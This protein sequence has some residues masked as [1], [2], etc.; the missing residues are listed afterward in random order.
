VLKGVRI[1]EG[2][3]SMVTLELSID[4][5]TQALILGGVE[6][7]TVARADEA[8]GQIQDGSVIA[9]RRGDLVNRLFA[10]DGLRRALSARGALGCRLSFSPWMSTPEKAPRRLREAHRPR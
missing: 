9:D 6:S 1:G 10:H 8:R 7:R 5:A 2:M 3:P 4:E